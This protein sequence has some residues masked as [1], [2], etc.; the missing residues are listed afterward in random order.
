MLDKIMKSRHC[1]NIK[2]QYW[3][4]FQIASLPMGDVGSSYNRRKGRRRTSVYDRTK[5]MVTQKKFKQ[6]H[7]LSCKYLFPFR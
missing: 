2:V 4:A 3:D 7:K 6:W 1:P 5:Y